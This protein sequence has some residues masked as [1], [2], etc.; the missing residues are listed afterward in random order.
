M[1]TRK[2]LK[3]SFASILTI[4]G[5]S[6]V[7]QTTYNYT[8]T[9]QTYIVPNNVTT[10][11]IE[12]WGGQGEDV[13]EL[14]SPQTGGLGGYST[15]D[16]AVTPGETL[17]IYV[18]G[19]GIAGVGGF[20]GGGNGGTATAASPDFGGSAGAGGG[21]SDIRQ[22][23]TTLNDRVIVAA[24][25]GGAGRDYTNGSCVP[26][27]TGGNGGA[28]GG[29]SGTNGE[30][31]LYTNDP[32]YS[33][34]TA[35]GVGA[36]STIGGTGGVGNDGNPGEDGL[37]GVGG[38]GINGDYNVASG[39]GGGGYYGG[40]SGAGTSSGSGKA[41][42]GGGGGSSF[43]G[44]VTNGITNS[45]I[46]SGDGSIIITA[47]CNT[48]ITITLT[49][50]DELFGSDASITMNIVSGTG[51]YTFDWDNDGTGDNDD[52]QDLTAI[53]SGSYVVVVT[54]GGACSTTESILV[55]TQLSIDETEKINVSVY[56]NPTSS[57]L[58]IENKGQFNYTLVDLNGATLLKGSAIDIEAVELDYLARGI[59]ML[60][61]NSED[62][63]TVLK[64]ILK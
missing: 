53:S 8:G 46:H 16:L 49:S 24:G 20:N 23:G 11:N 34:L 61:V 12:S 17:Y 10:I 30:E 25:G 56:P 37:L 21:A 6:S 5:F 42:G 35:G 51:P 15:G 3:W 14:Y 44:G 7:A 48:P 19:E 32:I 57:K 38:N 52:T 59:Y 43:I 27:G 22:G 18:G 47:V 58:T 28:G 39:G 26:C 4:T 33:N 60:N 31:A 40:G 9:V 13:S 63:T 36:T 45:G 50:T 2:L 29:L 54:D 41:A 1:K 55:G 62:N 64:V